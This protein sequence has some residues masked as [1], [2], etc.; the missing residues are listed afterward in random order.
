MKNETVSKLSDCTAMQYYKMCDNT[1]DIEKAWSKKTLEYW[2]DNLDDLRKE[3]AKKLS[4]DRNSEGMLDDV[5]SAMP[6]YLAKATDYN[7]QLAYNKVRETTISIKGYILKGAEN[8][9]NRVRTAESNLRSKVPVSLS[10]ELDGSDDYSLLDVL[11]D[12]KQVEELD[13]AEVSLSQL[14][15]LLDACRYKVSGGDMVTYIYVTTWAGTR[16]GE[17]PQRMK[18]KQQLCLLA[19]ESVGITQHVM[20][21]MHNISKMDTEVREITDEIDILKKKHSAVILEAIG[22]KVYGI[23]EINQVLGSF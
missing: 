20:L 1:G 5:M 15:R 11:E 3:I 18:D 14:E 7:K 9:I 12:K 22:K 6:E 16:D 23:N 8:V 4:N 17:S 21:N 10:M 2:N 13:A 19:L